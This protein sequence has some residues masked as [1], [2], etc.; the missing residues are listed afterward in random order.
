MTCSSSFQD[1][2]KAFKEAEKVA[3]QKENIV[4]K[5]PTSKRDEF[6]KKYNKMLDSCWKNHTK[7]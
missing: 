6:F 7:D 2:V 1:C 3:K 5:I 4:K